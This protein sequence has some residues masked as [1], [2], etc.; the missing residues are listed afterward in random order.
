VE[1]A[2]A[3]VKEHRFGGHEA[4]HHS[5]LLAV[6]TPCNVVDRSLLVE[7]DAAVKI[8]SC[9][10]KI[11]GRL[12]IVA[13]VGVVDLGLSDDQGLSSE[14]V[15][16]DLGAIGL[17]KVLCARWDAGKGKKTVNLDASRSTLFLRKKDRDGWIQPRTE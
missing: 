1:R 14:V 7:R 5:K 6:G 12:S 10:E 16:L 9:A 3:L 8:A 15:P 2:D 13:H 17:V 4:V 11:H